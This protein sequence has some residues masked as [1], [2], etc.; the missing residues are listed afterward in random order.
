M[1]SIE[2]L[3]NRLKNEKRVAII[4][5]VRPDGDCVGSGVALKLA[6]ESLGIPAEVFCSDDI[7]AR[8]FFLEEARKIRKDFSPEGFSAVIAVDCADLFRL[9]NFAES[10]RA[11][12]NTYEIDH[13]ISNTHFSRH[14]YVYERGANCENVMEIIK[15]AGVKID[16]K[17]ADYLLMGIMTDTGNFRHKN[18][19]PDTLYKSGELLAAGA[20]M[21]KIAYYMFSA[22]SKERAKLF[23]MTMS[24]IRYFEEDRIAIA[25]VRREML[26]KAGARADE[27]EG[28][29]DFVMGVVGVEVGACV[30]EIEKNK[31]KISLRSKSAD[32]NAIAGVFG[33]GGHVLASGCQVFGEYEEVIDRLVCA[34]KRFI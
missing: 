8:F 10:F 18:V 26:E 31:F 9:G 27:T 32:V 4:I 12:K 20:D 6:L 30:M 33:G 28:F 17:I 25:S 19:T 15:Q 1:I 5:H 3:A 11:Q 24:A 13:H 2:T 16:K 34:I 23:G 29:I 14:N 21:N 7:P 22:Q